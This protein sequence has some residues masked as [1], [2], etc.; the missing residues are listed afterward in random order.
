MNQQ[1]RMHLL[2]ERKFLQERLAELPDSARIMRISTE[3]RIRAIEKKI[4]NPKVNP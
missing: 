4:N 1:D 3:S 2:A